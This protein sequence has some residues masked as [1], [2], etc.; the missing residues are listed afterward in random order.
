MFVI[1]KPTTIPFR[2]VS[3]KRI[4]SELGFVA[5]FTFDEGIKETVD[6]Y[7]KNHS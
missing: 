5:Q 6:W 4:V 1:S 3:N 7:I 2:M